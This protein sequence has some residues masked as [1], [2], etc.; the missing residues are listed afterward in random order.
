MER[1]EIIFAASSWLI[2][3]ARI[4]TFSHATSFELERRGSEDLRDK[5][6]RADLEGSSHD[7]FQVSALRISSE[8]F[9]FEIARLR[10]R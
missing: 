9:P 4:G 1:S 3:Q 5:S 7:N 10:P 8:S 6:L 2:A